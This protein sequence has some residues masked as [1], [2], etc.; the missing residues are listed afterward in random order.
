ME[1]SSEIMDFD[2]GAQQFS[3]VSISSSDALISKRFNVG[4]FTKVIPFY[5]E[6][7]D[8]GDYFRTVTPSCVLPDIYGKVEW[9]GY[10]YFME[11]QYEWLPEDSFYYTTEDF[12]KEE[13]NYFSSYPASHLENLRC[14][15]DKPKSGTSPG[16]KNKIM[17]L[18]I[19]AITPKGGIGVPLLD[20]WIKVHCYNLDFNLKLYNDGRILTDAQIKEHLRYDPDA[21]FGNNAN[22]AVYVQALDGEGTIG[23]YPWKARKRN[24]SSFRNSNYATRFVI[25]KQ[26]RG[27]HLKLPGAVNPADAWS[28]YPS[29]TGAHYAYSYGTPSGERKVDYYS[30]ADR[31]VDK[32]FCPYSEYKTK[33]R[34][35]GHVD[36]LKDGLPGGGHINLYGTLFSP[37]KFKININD[38]LHSSDSASTAFTDTDRQIIT[39]LSGIDSYMRPY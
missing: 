10:M 34:F 33:Y 14:T 18:A 31:G 27:S 15:A 21:V 26:C 8:S 30:Y 5:L 39:K 28:C 12:V 4:I 32:M 20:S 11:E 9:G 1:P 7:V 37:V 38:S 6:Y 35:Y 22:D 25:V 17:E 36:I 19:K 2:E 29:G 24:K 23:S 16:F 3:S 13:F